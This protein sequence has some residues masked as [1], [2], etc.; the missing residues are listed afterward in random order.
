MAAI[1]STGGSKRADNPDRFILAKEA[2]RISWLPENRAK[3]NKR[4]SVDDNKPKSKWATRYSTI[5]N[6]IR[7]KQIVRQPCEVCGN[8][9]SQGHHEDYSKPLDVTWLCSKHHGERHKACRKAKS[10]ENK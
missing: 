7:N 9:K 1:G 4:K 5:R 2:A 10:S 3:R 6:A 8:P